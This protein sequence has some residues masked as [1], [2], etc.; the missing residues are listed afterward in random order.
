MELSDE[1]TAITH[2]NEYARFLGYD[3]CIRRCAKAKATKGRKL[4][5]RTLNNKVELIAPLKDKI[6]AFMFHE[7]IIQQDNGK[8]VLHAGHV[9]NQRSKLVL[10]KAKQNTVLLSHGISE[11]LCFRGQFFIR[12]PFSLIGNDGG[13]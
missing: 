1:K 6:E 9:T 2:S 5:M 3:I 8:M 12:E 10:T 4:P 13:V 7:G 11:M